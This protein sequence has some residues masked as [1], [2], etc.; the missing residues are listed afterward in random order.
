MITAIRDKFRYEAEYAKSGRASCKG[1]KSSISEGQFRVAKLVPS[2]H[3]DGMM[4]MWYHPKCLI[5]PRWRTSETKR[6]GANPRVGEFMNANMLAPADFLKLKELV[7]AT[8]QPEAADWKKRQDEAA[9]Q[10]LD[11]PWIL[12]DAEDYLSQMLSLA[13]IRDFLTS[14]ELKKAD[15]MD[16]CQINGLPHDKGSA[17]VFIPIIAEAVLFGVPAP[18]PSCGQ[19]LVSANTMYC[20]T[21]VHEWGS[22][23]FRTLTPEMKPFVWPAGLKANLIPDWIYEHEFTP[24]PRTK[25][26][27]N[28]VP[29]FLLADEVADALDEPNDEDAYPMMGAM[30]Q[31]SGYGAP[32]PG[33]QPQQVKPDPVKRKKA[34]GPR[35]PVLPQD[36]ALVAKCMPSRLSG[37]AVTFIGKLVTNRKVLTSQVEADGGFVVPLKVTTTSL[38][39]C[40]SFDKVE[41]MSNTK[42][43]VDKDIAIISEDD[44]T[45]FLDSDRSLPHFIEKA[46]LLNPDASFHADCRARVVHTMQKNALNAVSESIPDDL[47]SANPDKRSKTEPEPEEKPAGP[48]RVTLKAGAEVPVD[49]TFFEAGRGGEYHIYCGKYKGQPR[50]WA[51]MLNKTNFSEGTNSFYSMQLLEHD[52]SSDGHCVHISWGRV[53]DQNPNRATTHTHATLDDAKLE[54]CRT[55]MDKTGNDFYQFMSG[56]FSKKPG[57]YYAAQVGFKR[58]AETNLAEYRKVPSKLDPAIEAYVNLIFNPK[59]SEVALAEYEIDMSA[60]P[61]GQL[62]ES[63]VL[64]GMEILK[65]IEAIVGEIDR[66]R[67]AGELEG[68][69]KRSLAHQLEF[70]C[71]AYF[72]IIPRN[73]D[74]HST[75]LIKSMEAVKTEADL[76]DDLLEMARSASLIEQAAIKPDPALNIADTQY[77]AL[78]IGLSSKIDPDVEAA[79][80]T[81]IA[82]TVGPTHNDYSLSVDSI[83]RVC[84]KDDMA[85]LAPTRLLWHGSRLANLVGIMEHGLLMAPPCAVTSGY[86]FGKGVYT[87]ECV[88]KAANYC[89]PSA[90]NKKGVLLLCEVALGN[91]KDCKH[92]HYI[93][94]KTELDKGCDSVRGVGKWVVPQDGHTEVT[95]DNGR[96]SSIGTGK[97]V[98]N[99]AADDLLYDEYIVF[100]TDQVRIRYAVVVDFKPRR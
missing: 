57:K 88:T 73:M 56:Q 99:K 72:T 32:L 7:E 64:E 43:A 13:I 67:A 69:T 4:Q 23:K 98:V 34:L 51:V 65:A 37:L 28:F 96:T 100:D 61:L 66:A 12:P 60:M 84:S 50:T 77:A 82:Q 70:R 10:D 27:D 90:Q 52:T 36:H 31:G 74:R 11:E 71:N 41:S 1:C 87:A 3:F 9:D 63:Q 6:L 93:E 45:A 40:P 81:S 33:I 89:R 75:R 55:F 17:A 76:L 22:C 95:L 35:F 39:V 53:N 86:M 49:P 92:A 15:A 85:D 47:I 14:M 24:H 68:E 59:L 8:P 79:I 18:C 94:N 46:D 54:F 58:E 29:D 38:C 48:K 21:G 19:P 30:T 42:K 2:R 78:D 16:I 20:C 26:A 91:A 97:L 62:S 5:S 80:R 83:V 44:F 25:I